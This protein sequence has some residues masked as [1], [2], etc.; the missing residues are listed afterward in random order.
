MVLSLF[1]GKFVEIN[2]LLDMNSTRYA[3]TAIPRP[4]APR[5]LEADL[6]YLNSVLR[7]MRRHGVTK[8]NTAMLL[9]Y[10]RHPELLEADF[11]R[12]K[13]HNPGLIRFTGRKVIT[14]MLD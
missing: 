9:N 8:S 3:T 10:A 14:A 12:R 2:K 4:E 1:F 13:V 7:M 11:P 5:S 6:M